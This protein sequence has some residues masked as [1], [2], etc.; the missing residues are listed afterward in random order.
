VI[1]VMLIIGIHVVSALLVWMAG[2][3]TQD[4]ILLFPVATIVTLFS[5]SNAPGLAFAVGALALISA[6]ILFVQALK[7]ER[8]TVRLV[9]ETPPER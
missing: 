2:L 3:S 6:S 9:G 1:T 4:V 5:S 8:G 7:S